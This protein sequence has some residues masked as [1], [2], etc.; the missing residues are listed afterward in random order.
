MKLRKNFPIGLLKR[1]KVKKRG[2]GGEAKASNSRLLHVDPTIPTA[3]PSY[4]AILIAAHHEA[5]GFVY[6]G[7]KGAGVNTETL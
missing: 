3:P 1:R 7:K 4:S 5:G 2:K 6:L